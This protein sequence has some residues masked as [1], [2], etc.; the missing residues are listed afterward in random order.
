M[1][2]PYTFWANV[3]LAFLFANANTLSATKGNVL[4]KYGNTLLTCVWW[5]DAYEFYFLNS[6]KTIQQTLNYELRAF[7]QNKIKCFMPNNTWIAG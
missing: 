7:K 3:F 1:H 2:Y 6:S 5:I 4:Q